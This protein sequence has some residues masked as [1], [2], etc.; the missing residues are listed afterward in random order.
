MHWVVVDTEIEKE[1]PIDEDGKLNWN[2]ARNGNCGLAC[3]VVYDSESE[4]YHVY[5]KKSLHDLVFHLRTA[6]MVISFNGDGFDFPLLEALY[7]DDLDLYVSYDI[8]AEIWSILGKKTKGYKL[9]DIVNRTL[10]LDKTGDGAHAPKLWQEG[11]IAEVID[12]CINDV[13]ITR[14]LWEHIVE[15]GWIINADGGKLYFNNIKRDNAD[16]GR[17]NTSKSDSV[18]S[19][20]T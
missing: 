14:R 6:D 10:G 1:I 9:A 15:K 3:A 17:I 12:Y 4:R 2:E 19:S 16:E 11:H 18:S 20:A 7:K 13:H 5:D 8:L